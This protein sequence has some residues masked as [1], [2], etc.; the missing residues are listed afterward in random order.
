MLEL[1]PNPVYFLLVDDREANLVALEALLQREGLKC[2]KAHSGLEALELLL[3]YEVALALIDI[4]MP[5]MDGFEL[6]ELM[7]GTERTRRIP[8]IFL[9]AGQSDQQ[10]R[11][12][13]YETG[14]VDFLQKPIEEDALKSK[15]GVFFELFR[16]RQEVARQRDELA[17]MIQ[18]NSRL[19]EES[20]Q[21]THALQ[22]AD[23]RK[24]EFLATLA[25]ELRN[26]LAPILNTIQV[27]RL[28]SSQHEDP[29]SLYEIIERQVQ[30][31]VRLVDDL[32]E[33]RRITGGKIQLQLELLD[34]AE[35]VRNAIETSRPLMTQGK[36]EFALTPSEHP[37]FV[38]GDPVRLTQVIA[39]LLNNAAKYTPEGGRIELISTREGDAAVIRIRDTGLGVPPEMLDKVFDMF[40][41]INRHLKRSQ[42]GLGV[43]LTLVKRL[44]ELHGGSV[45]VASEGEGKGAEFT[46]RLP[47]AKQ[48][49]T[50][51]SSC[52][53][54]SKHKRSQ[55]ILIIDDNLDGLLS[56]QK[57]LTICGH[58]VTTAASGAAGIIQVSEHK[59][60]Y[61]FLDLGMP[62]M[63]GYETA[64][65][66]RGLPDGK[67]LVLVALTGWGQETDRHRT[68][69]AGFD[70]H[71][72][73][74]VNPA[75][76]EELLS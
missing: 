8:I 63:D 31:M 12:R 21:A 28:N 57:L 17:Q 20:R 67:D 14:A 45:A 55:K 62:D 48:T 76:L 66:L 29:S 6:A 47:L 71:L 5:G 3:N 15:A 51:E 73:K 75:A 9:T 10:R 65:R 27:L 52:D 61:V 38:L 54:P 7:R 26:P 70:H 33:V 59:P 74:P 60:A 1:L 30:H 18:T 36:H 69:A 42:G 43:G 56:L 22:E 11:F 72:V 16:Q 64:Q 46:V 19:L 2:L 58:E 24:D 40:T 50:T 34:V 25:H 4:Q 32:L 13:G 39:N 44:V 37:L 53:T 49:A 23:R 41:Q 35:V 68:R